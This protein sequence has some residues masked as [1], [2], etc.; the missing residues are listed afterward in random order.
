LRGPRPLRHATLFWSR[1]PLSVPGDHSRQR[2]VALLGRLVADLAGD[3]APPHQSR[4]LALHALSV[5]KRPTYLATKFLLRKG[6]SDESS[7]ICSLGCASNTCEEKE[8]PRTVVKGNECECVP[9]A[10]ST[11]QSVEAAVGDTPLSLLRTGQ[12][13]GCDKLPLGVS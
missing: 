8:S 9:G 5:T 6:P 12:E 7:T 4:P 1:V 13:L 2:T 3:G 10:D 11:G